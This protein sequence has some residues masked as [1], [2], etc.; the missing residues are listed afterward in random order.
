M[1]DKI[2][3]RRRLTE[4]RR[5]TVTRRQRGEASDPAPTVDKHTDVAVSL[6]CKVNTRAHSNTQPGGEIWL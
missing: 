1:K 6:E 5:E 2:R 4:G 3:R